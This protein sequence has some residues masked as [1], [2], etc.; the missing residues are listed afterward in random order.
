MKKVSISGLNN[1]GKGRNTTVMD[2]SDI[3]NEKIA[4]LKLQSDVLKWKLPEAL[5]IDDMPVTLDRSMVSYQMG[6]EN[7]LGVRRSNLFVCFVVCESTVN[8]M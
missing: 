8:L 5:K 2:R 7:V 1:A 3:L 4:L 6:A